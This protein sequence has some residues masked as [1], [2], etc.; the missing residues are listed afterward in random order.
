MRYDERVTTKRV[1]SL[2]PRKASFTTNS[3]G[4]PSSLISCFLVVS[5][6]ANLRVSLGSLSKLL[7]TLLFRLFHMYHKIHAN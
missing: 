5:V 6:S 3:R 4:I 7:K 2:S 1:S